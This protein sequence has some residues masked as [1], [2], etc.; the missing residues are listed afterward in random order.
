MKR[1]SRCK[2]EKPEE[3][4]GTCR[5]IRCSWCRVCRRL[6]AARYRNENRERCRAATRE[7]MNRNT[8]RV[9]RYG[10]AWHLS[11]RERRKQDVR[12]R[13][14]GVDHGKYTLLVSAQ[15]GG[16][17]ICGKPN[18]CGRDLAVDHDHKTG[19]VR[20]LLCT[21]CNVVLGLVHDSPEH[22]LEAALY[23]EARG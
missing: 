6:D 11:N 14:Y 20:G 19:Q 15:G 18:T 7:W 2:E 17:A 12:K 10:Q 9:A 8:A 1:C 22:L 13:R 21:R 4:F 16:C 23:L 5:G 3:A